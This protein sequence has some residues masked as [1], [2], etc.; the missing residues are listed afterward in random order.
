MRL[1][2]QITIDITANDY[3][4]A[5]QH[6]RYIEQFITTIKEKYPRAVLSI[7]ERRERKVDSITPLRDGIETIHPLSISSK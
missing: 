1:R 4:D 3:V 7:R 2:A 6:Q 5:A